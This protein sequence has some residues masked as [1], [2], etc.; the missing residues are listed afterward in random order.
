M[1]VTFFVIVVFCVGLALV[2]IQITPPNDRSISYN[3]VEGSR[4]DGTLVALDD[5]PT[6][7]SSRTFLQGQ[8]HDFDISAPLLCT[9]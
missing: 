6:T 5:G 2:A 8:Y 3:P 7:E 9:V 4:R 1:A